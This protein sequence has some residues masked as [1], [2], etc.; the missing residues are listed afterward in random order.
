MEDRYGVIQ[1]DLSEVISTLF[2]LEKVSESTLY[3]P[4]IY[5]NLLRSGKFTI[6]SL[7]QN[8][9]AYVKVSE[10]KNISRAQWKNEKLCIA[11]SPK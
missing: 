11:L 5:K 3:L 1:K 8:F 2:A 7:N 6:F 4:L 9:Y 10:T